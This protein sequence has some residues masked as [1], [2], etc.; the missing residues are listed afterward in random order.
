M[1]VGALRHLVTLE[2][3]G[4]LV[5]DGRGGYT[6]AWTGLSPSQVYASIMPATARDL[7]RQVASS[8]QATASHIITIRYH[9][10]V[11]TQTRIT[12][13]PRNIDDTLPAGSR[14]FIVTG[15]QNVEERNIELRI[16]AEEV[17]P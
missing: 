6:Q 2:N 11:T 1:D 12:K 10:G 15:V 16:A 7:E 4:A 3:P 17:V 9:P 13:G 5:P 14:E 8:V